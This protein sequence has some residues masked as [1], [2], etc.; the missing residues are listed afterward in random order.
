MDRTRD[1]VFTMV[2]GLE[3]VV[4]PEVRFPDMAILTITFIVIHQ[5]TWV[6]QITLKPLMKSHKGLIQK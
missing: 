3:P 1:T 5:T 2:M 6:P 4:T